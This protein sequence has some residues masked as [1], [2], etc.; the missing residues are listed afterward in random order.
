MLKQAPAAADDYLILPPYHRAGGA[1]TSIP[2][3]T[4]SGIVQGYP[5]HKLANSGRMHDNREHLCRTGSNFYLFVHP[6][7]ARPELFVR[8]SVWIVSSDC[9]FARAVA[10]KSAA[11][12]RAALSYG[13]SSRDRPPAGGT[14]QTGG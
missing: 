8:Q 2:V 12:L 10:A 1:F 13:R 11:E 3:S 5:G 6:V 9:L 14:G 7:A 4:P